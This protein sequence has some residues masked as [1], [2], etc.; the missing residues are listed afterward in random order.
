MKFSESWLREWVNHNLDCGQLCQQ[1][2]LSG[3]EVEQMTA[4]AGEF[5]GV[6]TGEVLDC[7]P[8]P[9]ADKLRV[10]KVNT[11][12]EQLLT[13]VCGAANCRAGIKVAVATVGAVLPGNFNIKAA[14]L[15]GETSQGM[16]CSASELGIAEESEGIM[17][18]APDAPVGAD[19]RNYLQLDDHCVEISVTPNRADCL[20]IIGIARDVAALNRLPLKE[21]EIHP[22]TATTGDKISIEIQEPAACPRYL[23]QVIKGINPNVA[24]PL[25]M[26]EKLRRC[27]L[28]S[29]DPVVDV[30]NYVLLEL[31]QPMHAFNLAKIDGGIVVR[32]ARQEEPLTLLDGSQIQLNDNTL[33]IADHR[34]VLGMAG[35]FGG[36]DSGVDTDTRD[37]FLECAFFSPSAISGRARD[38]GLRTE[39]SHRYER[40]VDADLQHK[41]LARAGGLLLDICGGEAGPVVDCSH[42]QHL[43][44]PACI[45]LRRSK[46]DS[47]TGHHIADH[48]VK[49]I[50]RGLGFAVN[51]QQDQWQA[52]APSWRF[53]MAIEEDLIEEVARIYGYHN[54]P[55]QPLQANLIMHPQPEAS[56]SLQRVKTLLTDRDYQEVITYSFVDP[57]VQQLLH[58]GQQALSLPVPI[59]SDMSVMRLSLWTG[60]LSALVYNQNRQQKRLRIFETGLRFVPDQHAELGIRQELILAGA[61]CGNRY[62]EHWDM[63]K[64][65]AD[66]YDVKGDVE[67]ILQLTGKLAQIRFQAGTEP[68]LHPGQTA[69]ICQGEQR[70]GVIGALHP[71]L[72]SKLQLNGQTLVFELLWSAINCRQVPVAHEIS[73][74][75][76]MRRDIALVVA[77]EVSAADILLECKKI[78]RNQLVGVN[79]FDIY[80]GKGVA[81]GDKSLAISLH[82]Q[83]ISRTLEE[84]EIAAIVARCVAA[85]KQ[86]F[87]ASLRD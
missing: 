55:D 59:S 87:N 81:Q 24:T 49:D 62:D 78:G 85:L 22:L 21:P 27:G 30:T 72:E 53:D 42:P 45:T 34:K 68:A 52:L 29:I 23:G 61:I 82:L 84:D 33:V 9:N 69:V 76:S 60:L 31:G 79:L 64:Q 74:F 17:E 3:L 70:I 5:T 75:P 77:E 7:V 10:A 25:W 48:E 2:T 11:G 15:R 40:G 39:A 83:D 73:R 14:K 51:Q 65:Q 63:D 71:G 32:M 38:Y 46:L 19:L 6:I 37:I 35:I 50:L 20:S 36:K 86:K 4:V 43:P 47:L 28:R 66:F 56:L 18:L 54:I 57:A 26:Q 41:A 8:H 12:G 44:V 16:L 80:Q 58:P 1:I 67:A 13:I